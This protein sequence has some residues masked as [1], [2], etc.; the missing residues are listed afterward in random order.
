MWNLHVLS[1]PACIQTCIWG[2][3]TP[4]SPTPLVGSHVYSCLFLQA[5]ESCGEQGKL[6]V[7]EPVF[8]MNRMQQEPDVPVS[9]AL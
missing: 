7:S 2:E 5:D 9:E 3:L 4:L 8:G 1:V 6:N